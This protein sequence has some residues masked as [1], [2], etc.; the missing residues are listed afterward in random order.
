MGWALRPGP[1]RG[2]PG[3]QAG[4]VPSAA[5][6]VL[7]VHGCTIF[8]QCAVGIGGAGCYGGGWEPNGGI[9]GG[10]CRGRRAGRGTTGRTATASPESRSPVVCA[11]SV[12][13]KVPSVRHNRL[14]AL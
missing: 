11:A 10:G 4:G 13:V 7:I 6:T 2:S 14:I 12:L 1:R 5:D 3:G 9:R 8:E